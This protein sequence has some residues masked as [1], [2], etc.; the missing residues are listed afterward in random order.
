MAATLAGCKTA[1]GGT[2]GLF[3]TASAQMGTETS[4]LVGGPFL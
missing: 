2:A 3:L 4:L 1:L